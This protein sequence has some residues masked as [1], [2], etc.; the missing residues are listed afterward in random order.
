MSFFLNRSIYVILNE[1]FILEGVSFVS[2]YDSKTEEQTMRMYRFLLIIGIVLV[3][4]NLRPG[5][6]SVGPLIGMIRDD[7]G[8]ANWSAG[9]LTS[10]PLLAFAAISPIVPILSQRLTNDW[11]MV[12]GLITIIIG[13]T[14]RSISFVAFLFIGTILVGLGIAICN[15]LLPGIVKDKFP[16]K[17]A[18]MTSV[19]STTMGVFA[20]IASGLSVPF[21]TGLNWGW[22]LSLFVWTIPAVIGMIIWIY[23]AKRNRTTNGI[24]LVYDTSVNGKIWRSSLAWQ[25][26][27]FMGLQSS[28][29][30]VTISWL[31]EILHHNG[32]SIT[33]AGW[34]LSYTQLIGMPASFIIPVI[35]GRLKSQKVLVFLLGGSAITGFSGLLLSTS[36]LAIVISTTFLGIALGGCFALALTFLAIRAKTAKD[37]GELSGMAQSIGYLLAALGPVFI[38]FLHDLTNEW[39]VPLLVLIGV[40]ILVIIFGTGAGQD[41]YVLN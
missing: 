37:A 35:A 31:P 12:V 6:T 15:V 41:K 38:G 4:F 8:L 23:L 40:T 36:F 27:L 7:I 3:A 5:M 11:T 17:V 34:I 30:Y 1:Q 13:I 26:A 33:T 28:L 2:L 32:L 18:L 16:T 19:Y 29:F 9:L 24:Q 25:V 39:T 21:A 10:L 14:I 22:K 20:A